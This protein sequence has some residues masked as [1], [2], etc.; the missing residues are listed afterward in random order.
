MRTTYP[1]R[2]APL[3][4]AGVVLA[5]CGSG[6]EKTPAA[7]P[8]DPGRDLRALASAPGQ[9]RLGG[10]T[11]ISACIV[12]GQAAGELETSG[13]SIV[14]AATTLNSEERANPGRPGSVEL[15]YLVGAV[16]RGA[17]K[18]GGIHADLVRRLDSAAR[19]SP[20][21]NLPAGFERAYGTG[22]AAG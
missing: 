9:V 14:V 11:P 19:F 8:G 13:H 1:A 5:A 17:S 2:L 6:N 15:G 3:L 20:Q 10:T 4:F 7:C 16:S 21:G 22:Y 18:T 12:R